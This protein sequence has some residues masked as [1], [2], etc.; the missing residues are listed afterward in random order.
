MCC[1][2]CRAAAEWIEQLGLADY[3][4]LAHGARAET[5]RAAKPDARFLADADSRA[6]R[7]PRSGRRTCAK[8]CC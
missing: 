2:G 7:D 8:P 3:Y 6:P 1:Q 5:G 4:R